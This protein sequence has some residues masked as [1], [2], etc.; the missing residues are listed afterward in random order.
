MESLSFDLCHKNENDEYIPIIRNLK[1]KEKK[2][3][4]LVFEYVTNNSKQ[5]IIFSIKNYETDYSVYPDVVYNNKSFISLSTDLNVHSQFSNYLNDLDI[6]TS[7]EYGLLSEIQSLGVY[8]CKEFK[9]GEILEKYSVSDTVYA[10]VQS[11]PDLGGSTKI[12]YCDPTFFNNSFKAGDTIQVEAGLSDVKTEIDSFQTIPDPFTGLD[13]IEITCVEDLVE[14]S[15]YQIIVSDYS[16]D[17]QEVELPSFYYNDEN[18]NWFHI[19]TVTATN[20]SK[21]IT[22]IIDLRQYFVSGDVI[23]LANV[24][25]GTQYSYEI[26]TINATTIVLTANF[27]ETTGS[28]KIYANYFQ[29]YASYDLIIK[30]FNGRLYGYT[31]DETIA[32]IYGFTNLLITFQHTAD[33]AIDFRQVGIFY[34]NVDPQLIYLSENKKIALGLNDVIDFTVVF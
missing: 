1:F 2:S 21:N 14:D 26:D 17:E 30:S 4:S 3:D 6:T 24:S 10:D 31:R 28:T 33:P 7:L 23:K 8:W 9:G 20:G 11:A 15:A 25:T 29:P 22:T 12:L 13:I 19:D 34:D 32:K 18:D 16:I 27:N 5:Y